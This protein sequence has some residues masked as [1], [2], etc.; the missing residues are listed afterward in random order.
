MTA[1]LTLPHALILAC[2]SG[3][4]FCGGFVFMSR[5]TSSSVKELQAT[6]KENDTKTNDKLD[7]IISVQGDQRLQSEITKREV[8]LLI[9][10]I[11]YIENH[12][13]AS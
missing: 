4:F 7:K 1:I 3:I 9:Q 6:V 11:T 12:L 5:N 10:R 13:K 2:I 8:D